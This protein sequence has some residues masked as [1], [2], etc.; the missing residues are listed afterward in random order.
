[1]ARDGRDAGLGFGEE[2]KRRSCWGRTALAG[3][4]APSTEGA[5]GADAIKRDFDQAVERFES[6]APTSPTTEFRVGEKVNDPLACICRCVHMP[7]NV[8]G[9]PG[10]SGVRL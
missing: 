7:V 4:Y 2:V 3:Y 6:C 10:I 9:L 8:A 5:E 1:M